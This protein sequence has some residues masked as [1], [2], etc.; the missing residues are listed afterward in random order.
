MNWSTLA[1]PGGSCWGGTSKSMGQQRSLRVAVGV[2]GSRVSLGT[3][4]LAQRHCPQCHPWLV[5]QGH[6]P[7][8]CATAAAEAWGGGDSI[9]SAR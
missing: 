4:G 2:S 8:Q 9:E 7:L 6:G 1:G 3:A 5:L